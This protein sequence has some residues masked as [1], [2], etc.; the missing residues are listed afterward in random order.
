MPLP[1]LVLSN[2]TT[3]FSGKIERVF[4][5]AKKHG[6]QYLEIVPY[7]W[8]SPDEVLRLE[9][10]YQIQV[11]GIH[12]PEWWDKPTFDLRTPL[13]AIYLGNGK[14]SPALRLAE[15]LKT[16]G[17]D[18]YLL[19]HSDVAAAMGEVFQK[20]SSRFHTVL[21][22][23]PG[24]PVHNPISV[25][26][27]GHFGP[28]IPQLKPEIIHISYNHGLFPHT[29][30]NK[31]EQAEL[32]EMLKIYKPRYIVIETNPLVSV[33][34]A[35]QIIENLT[36]QASLYESSTHQRKLSVLKP[37]LKELAPSETEKK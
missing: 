33:K 18:F 14:H 32:Q 30:P 6:F 7:R 27:P 24:E 37:S 26:D 29:L 21:E 15:K 13:W 12:M 9:Q 5:K 28:G 4:Q 19:F 10:K 22:N 36:S 17:R 20:L 8:T 34:K 31:R 16:L 25:F 35:K 1:K 2:T 23:V 11:V 3:F